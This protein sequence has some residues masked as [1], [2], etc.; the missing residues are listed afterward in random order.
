MSTYKSMLNLLLF[1]FIIV[2]S[3]EN[4]AFSIYEWQASI[5]G[6]VVIQGQTGTKSFQINGNIFA[7]I[8]GINN[9]HNST[10]GD[11]PLDVVLSFGDPSGMSSSVAYA[12][13][14]SLEFSTHGIWYGILG[15]PNI[16]LAFVSINGACVILQPD[17]KR[18][19]YSERQIINTFSGLGAP[20]VIYDGYIQLCSNDGFNTINGRID[21]NGYKTIGGTSATAHYIANVQGRLHSIN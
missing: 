11:N 5:Q 10:S 9:D 3:N 4:N 20:H 6:Q 19:S 21:V 8:P 17:M 2:F 13:T 15:R 7:I 1:L 18:L 16:D 12:P 14:G